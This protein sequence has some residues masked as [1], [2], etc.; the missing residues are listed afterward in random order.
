MPPRH[1]KGDKG[2]DGFYSRRF[3]VEKNRVDV[4][5]H[6]ID[7]NERNVKPLRQPTSGTYT[8]EQ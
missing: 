3:R 2:H 8:H 4:S 7:G 6:V 1:H 5:L